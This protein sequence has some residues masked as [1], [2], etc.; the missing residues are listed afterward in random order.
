ML[1]F[2][3][4]LFCHQ[5]FFPISN[6]DG[7]CQLWF[8]YISTSLKDFYGSRR[9]KD[10]GNFLISLFSTF[11]PGIKVFVATSQMSQVQKSICKK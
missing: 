11:A 1:T 6:I 9:R 3:Q 8:K 7:M 5:V 4:L 2:I 10:P